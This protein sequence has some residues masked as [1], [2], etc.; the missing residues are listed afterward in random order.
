[1]YRKG[2]RKKAEG[3]SEGEY[4]G[5]SES[6]GLGAGL[7]T[8]SYIHLTRSTLRLTPSYGKDLVVELHRQDQRFSLDRLLQVILPVPLPLSPPLSAWIRVSLA[9]A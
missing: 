1:M 4:K 5:T 9:A 8:C 6:L 7:R 3:I 2:R